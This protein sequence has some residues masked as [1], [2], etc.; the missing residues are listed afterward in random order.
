MIRQDREP[1]EKAAKQLAASPGS[2]ALVA[3]YR[4]ALTKFLIQ[5]PDADTAL[6]EDYRAKLDA[7]P[8]SN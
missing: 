2:A 5:H 7:L 4:D 6:I 8:R 1:V 3:Q